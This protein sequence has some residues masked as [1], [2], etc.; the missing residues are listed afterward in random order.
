MKPQDVQQT[1]YTEQ[2]DVA[3]AALQWAE[4]DRK[5]STNLKC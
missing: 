2:A 4:T 5:S 3:E 1:T